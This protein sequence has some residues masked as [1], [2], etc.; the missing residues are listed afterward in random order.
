[1]RACIKFLHNMILEIHYTW[2][3][4][5]SKNEI[6]I[7]N[8]ICCKLAAKDSFVCIHKL[9]SVW[10]CN[11]S[12]FQLRKWYSFINNCST[13]RSAQ[14]VLHL[15]WNATETSS[16]PVT[17]SHRSPPPTPVQLTNS[18]IHYSLQNNATKHRYK[19]NHLISCMTLIQ[20]D[21]QYNKL[22]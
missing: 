1:M 6:N 20:G 22:K 17:W 21:I 11:K 13:E 12:C 2:C 18:C 14:K 5:Q 8:Q 3:L 7:S 4:L 16:Q 15:C 10:R 9:T 19:N